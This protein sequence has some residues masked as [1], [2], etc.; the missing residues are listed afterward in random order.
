[1]TDC[2]PPWPGL[3]D[4]VFWLLSTLTSVCLMVSP[5]SSAL[6]GPGILR[7]PAEQRTE[8]SQLLLATAASAARPCLAVHWAPSHEW[9]V[10]AHP[11]LP[12]SPTLPPALWALA[13]P[14]LATCCLLAS[15]RAVSLCCLLVSTYRLL[16][17]ETQ[18]VRPE[19]G[20]GGGQTEG[21]R[22]SLCFTHSSNC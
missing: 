22:K 12:C 19:G 17:K 14:F 9:N 13:S 3:L 2:L 16:A 15:T 20:P 4:I 5:P 6:P 11:H 8:A 18:R 10:T 7:V 1:M 21:L